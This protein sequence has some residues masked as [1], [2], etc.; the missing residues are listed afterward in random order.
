MRGEIND[1]DKSEQVTE[2]IDEIRE[3]IKIII[4]DNGMKRACLAMNSSIFSDR[5]KIMT[6]RISR[7]IE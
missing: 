3:E 1:R 4:E 6:I 5:S 7:E 2:K